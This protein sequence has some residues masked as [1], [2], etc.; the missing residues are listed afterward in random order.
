[1]MFH[2][3]AFTYRGFPRT[4][5]PHW[6]YWLGYGRL[7]VV[8]FLILSGFSLAYAAAARG[9]RLGSIRE[10]ARR[11]A[12]RILP[13]YWAALAFSLAVAWLVVKQPHSAPPTRE[14]V[15]VYGLLLQDLIS[16]P[17]PNGAFWSIGVEALLYLLFPLLIAITRRV[18]VWAMLAYATVPVLLVAV[19]IFNGAPPEGDYRLAPHLLPVFAAGIAAAGIATATERIRRLPWFAFALAASVPAIALL[20]HQ[21]ARWTVNHYFWVDLAVTPSLTLLV[22]ALATARPAPLVRLL[23]TRP[24]ARLGACSYS[25]YLTHVPIVFAI[26]ERVFVPAFGH[27]SRAFAATTVVA[28]TASLLAACLFARLF[29]LPFQRHRSW[30]ALRY[31]RKVSDGSRM[32]R[33]AKP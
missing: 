1:M 13:A 26:S 14:S 11:R 16:A 20:L 3:W 6:L 2:V 8:L 33:A 27:G 22:V 9:W 25:M 30:S 15:V 23:E 32:L 21:G 10:F 12:W 18:G 5:S 17:T 19:I 24:L 28:G 29:E 7:A 4:R 31:G